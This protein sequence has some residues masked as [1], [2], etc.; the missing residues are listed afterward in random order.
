[1][2]ED[3]VCISIC[4]GVSTVDEADGLLPCG[5]FMQAFFIILV[6]IFEKYAECFSSFAF[7]QVSD[8]IFCLKP[9]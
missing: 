1:V 3:G 8:G 4:I 7:L 9:A 6:V 2:A 5:F